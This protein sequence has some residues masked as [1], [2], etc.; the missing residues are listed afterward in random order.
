MNMC[1]HAY[2]YMCICALLLLLALYVCICVHVYLYI[3]ICVSVRSCS[4]SRPLALALERPLF[5]AHAHTLS[6]LVSTHILMPAHTPS[7]AKCHQAHML[8]V[9]TRI[10]CSK[11]D[12]YGIDYT[13]YASQHTEHMNTCT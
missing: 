7:A 10:Y 13:E 3:C 2:A 9:S 12:Q 4:C 5:L 11:H 1:I 6:H 8:S